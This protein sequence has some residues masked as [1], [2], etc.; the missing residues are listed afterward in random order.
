MEKKLCVFC[1]HFYLSPG[2]PGHS[3]YTPGWDAEMGCRKDIISIDLMI[4]STGSYRR[5]IL[6][7]KTCKDYTPAV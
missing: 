1:E 7:A 4:D 5:K 2:D 3:E 6:L